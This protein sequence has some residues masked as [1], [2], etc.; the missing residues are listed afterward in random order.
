[1][2]ATPASKRQKKDPNAEL[3][4]RY[5]VTSSNMEIED[6]STIQM[7]LKGIADE[8]K[9]A[10]PRESVLLPLFRSTFAERRLFILNDASSIKEIKECY[11]GLMLPAVVSVNE[12]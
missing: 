2:P 3:L 6:A 7:N 5:P 10:K 9:R 11:P 1:M 12:L 4:R 8:L